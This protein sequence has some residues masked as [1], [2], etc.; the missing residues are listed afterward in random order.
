MLSSAF[1]SGDTKPKQIALGGG[2]LA[3]NTTKYK[4]MRTVKAG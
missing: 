2:L 1:S 3:F 4:I